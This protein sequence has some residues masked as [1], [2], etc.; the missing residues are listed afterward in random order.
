MKALALIIGNSKYGS[1]DLISPENDANDLADKLKSF[2]F[3]VKKDINVDLDR[4]N[5]IVDTFGNDLN[6]YDVGVFY[7]A[8]HGMQIDG[9]N[10]LTAT[11]TNFESEVAAKYSSVTLYKILDHMHRAKKETNIVI[12]DACRNNPYER[13]WSRS[14]KQSGLAPLHAPKGTFIAFATS[15]GEVASNGTGRNGLYTQCL[16]RHLDDPKV[17][18]EEL[19]KR[20]RNSVYTFSN[21]KQT[22]WEHTSL[23]GKFIFNSGI[24]IQATSTEYPYEALADKYYV[25]KENE[26]DTII[27]DLKSS[28]WYIQSPAISQIYNLEPEKAD[29]AQLFVLGRNI[30]QTAQGGERAAKAFLENIENNARKFDHEGHNHLLNGILFEIY[31]DNEGR[32]RGHNLKTAAFDKIMYLFKNDEF[33]SSFLFIY[34]QLEPFSEDLMF[35]PSPQANSINLDLV[36]EKAESG[37]VIEYKVK[38]IKHE[39]KEMLKE[40]EDSWLIRTNG[41]IAYQPYTFIRLKQEIAKQLGVPEQLLILSANYTID[42]SSRLLY[43][44]GYSLSKF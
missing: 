37:N 2:G 23:T 14:E 12:L 16:L 6:K 32:F 26:V 5:V 43:P 10:Y 44:F 3:T 8:G 41:D 19:F 31:F 35:I 17:Q 4:F 24:Y 9:D 36:L 22:S 20:V 42:N 39:G 40:Q 30:L 21:N 11:N 28:N 18:I 29:I 27:K 13:R 1:E 33:T 34:Q 15:P 25:I 7:F 38:E